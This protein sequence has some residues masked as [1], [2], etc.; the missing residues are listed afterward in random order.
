MDSRK[1]AEYSTLATQAILETL[2]QSKGREGAIGRALEHINDD[3]FNGILK[4]AAE[5]MGLDFIRMD[6]EYGILLRSA[7]VRGPFAPTL[8]WLNKRL[9]FDAATS[10][11]HVDVRKTEVRLLSGLMLVALLSDL[12]PTADSVRLE[13]DSSM[14]IEPD[15]VVKKLNEIAESVQRFHQDDDE[16]AFTRMAQIITEE[17]VPKISREMKNSLSATRSQREMAQRWINV[18]HEHGLLVED[19]GLASDTQWMATRR[20]KAYIKE[21]GILPLVD[22]ILSM[23]QPRDVQRHDER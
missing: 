23:Q 19:K 20:L 10:S 12:F 11:E 5:G 17:R 22:S 1:L 18:L 21:A 4:G 14:P 9:G 8:G 3:L 16:N 2:G 7:S 15:S 6:S 13:W